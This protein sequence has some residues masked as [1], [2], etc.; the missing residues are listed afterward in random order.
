M[1]YQIGSACVSCG[2]C[3]DAC[4]VGA[5]SQDTIFLEYKSIIQD[6]YT[7]PFLVLIYVISVHHT[8]LGEKGEKLRLSTFLSL[9][10]KSL[11]WVVTV[12]GLTQQALMPICLIYLVTVLSPVV[13]P[14]FLSS[15]VIFGAP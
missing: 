2:A 13:N 3:A 6:R 15:A 14:I 12:Y 8:A 1:A 10:E 9:F 7:N 4:P 11:L 5:I